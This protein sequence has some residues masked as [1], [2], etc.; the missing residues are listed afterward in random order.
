MGNYQGGGNRGGGFRGGNGGGRPS[1]PK[2]SWGNDRDGDRPMHKA[3]CA[4]CGKICEV[5]FRPTGD[6]PVYCSDCF[7]SKRGSDDRGPRRD[8]GDRAPR[9]DFNDRSASARPDFSRPSA[10]GGDEMKKQLSEISLKLDRLVNAVERLTE[11]KKEA[12]APKVSS[13]SKKEVKKPT[14][15]KAVIKKAVSTKAPAKKS[16]S[17]KK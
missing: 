13:E 1:F 17:K 6:K 11:N 15:L 7:S 8:F 12:V 10:P 14:N 2:K 16:V 9:R 3:T 5:P 4:E